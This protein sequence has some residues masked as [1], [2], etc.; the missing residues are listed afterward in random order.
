MFFCVFLIE[1]LKKTVFLIELLFFSPNFRTF[2]LSSTDVIGDTVSH[3][4]D[5][6]FACQSIESAIFLKFVHDYL[7][8][9]DWNGTCELYVRLACLHITLAQSK[10][11][12]QC[13][14]H[15]DNEYLRN[16]GRLGNITVTMHTDNIQR[17]RHSGIHE[18]NDNANIWRVNLNRLPA[19]RLTDR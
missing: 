14:A 8:N 19:G 1:F 16:C 11:Q 6:L 7:A 3:D 15:F 12:G 4:T 2:K 13:H 10:G 17:D 9:D 18:N 5:L